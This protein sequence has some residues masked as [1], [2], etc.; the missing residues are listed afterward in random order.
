MQKPSTWSSLLQFI[1]SLLGSLLLWSAALL[2]AGLGLAGS[3]EP[4]L[5]AENGLALFSMAASLGFIGVLLLPSAV[6]ALDRL[7]DGPPRRAELPGWLRRVG[8]GSIILLPVILLA[9]EWANQNGGS[10]LL[11]VL[12]ILAVALPV[13][14]F[15]MIASRG[16][17]LGSAQRFWGVFA[18]GVFI[19]PVLAL[20]LELIALIVMLTIG[21]LA[22]S[23]QPELLE[24]ITNLLQR[25]TISPP[26]PALLQRTLSPYL[27]S[28]AVA[29][30][31]LVYVAGLVPL[32]EEAVKPVGLWLISGKKLTPAQ[33]F[34]GGMLSGAGFAIFESLLLAT[35]SEDWT[36]MLAARVAPGLMHIATTGTIGYALAASWQDRRYVRLGLAYLAAV[37]AHGLWNGI[38]VLSA[39]YELLAVSPNDPDPWLQLGRFAPYILLGV[40]ALIMI[41]LYSFSRMLVRREQQAARLSVM[42]PV[43]L[44]GDI[45]P[46]AVETP[47]PET[48]RDA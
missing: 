19:G 38:G 15:F 5:G 27:R 25:L 7:M 16:L 2:L 30:A 44:T 35:G 45:L 14:W 40:S 34:V 23:S 13:S 46:A 9:G 21:Y 12:Q 33:G 1:F 18:A 17:K 43:M 41:W 11:P 26:S 20:L 3:L 48:E 24:E 22:L 37:A 39:G 36:A 10:W 29:G 42:P 28:P 31:I 6:F 47:K 8:L 32:L 4:A